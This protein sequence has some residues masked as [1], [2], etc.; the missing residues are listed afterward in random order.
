MFE[1]KQEKYNYNEY[2]NIKKNIYKVQ[3]I[4]NSLNQESI[5][6]FEN[7]LQKLNELLS[8]VNFLKY[9]I[10][11]FKDPTVTTVNKTVKMC[12]MFYRNYKKQYLYTLDMSFEFKKRK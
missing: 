12:E 2:P 7:E 9:A 6:S 11:Y 3:P 1:S 8:D 4:L 10:G 5:F